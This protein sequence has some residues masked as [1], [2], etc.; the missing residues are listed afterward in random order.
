MPSISFV[1][2]D[3]TLPMEDAE[4]VQFGCFQF[5]ATQT[6][7]SNEAN[8]IFLLTEESWGLIDAVAEVDPPKV[9]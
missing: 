9:T 2:D 1:P 6:L 7:G 3:L 5:T 4:D 8:T